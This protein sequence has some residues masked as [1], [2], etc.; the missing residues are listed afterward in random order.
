MTTLAEMTTKL[1][2]L[3]L[4]EQQDLEELEDEIAA[5]INEYRGTIDKSTQ[6]N[7]W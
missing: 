7:L 4:A 1:S 5:I 3:N 6:N 2:K